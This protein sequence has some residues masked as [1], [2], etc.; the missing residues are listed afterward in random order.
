VNFM[1][2]LLTLPKFSTNGRTKDFKETSIVI[3]GIPVLR[4]AA[5]Y[6]FRNIQNVVKK[7]QALSNSST[8]VESPFDYVEVMACPSG[9]TNGGSQ[10]ESALNQEQ[11]L[12]KVNALYNSQPVK[13]NPTVGA[14]YNS[15]IKND[16]VLAAEFLHTTYSKLEVHS[17]KHEQKGGCK[18]SKA[19]QNK[20]VW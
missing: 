14:L 17:H 7:I 16:R 10:I 1:A 9:C 5:A 18:C 19:I 15:W 20:T 4:F 8:P 6:G 13:S 11:T 3:D 12:D 2:S